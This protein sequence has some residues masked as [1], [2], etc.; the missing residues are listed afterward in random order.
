MFE[1]ALPKTTRHY[2][3]LLAQKGISRPFY[4]AGGTAV[5]LHLGHRIS[6]DFDFFTPETFDV[7]RL[8]SELRSFDTYRR[9]RLAEDTLLGALE[10]VRISFFRYRYNLLE[11]PIIF[12]GTQILQLPDLAA[13]KIEAIAQ[14]NVKRDFIDLYFLATRAG[15]SVEKALEYHKAKFTGFDINFGHIVLSLGYFDEADEDD[16]PQMLKPVKWADVKK[17]FQRESKSLTE[18]LLK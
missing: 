13:M 11:S 8:E 18:K 15:I 6:V 2:L 16:M 1:Q 9:E 4:L 14:R 5:A 7:N 10:D 3:D 17:Y 12:L